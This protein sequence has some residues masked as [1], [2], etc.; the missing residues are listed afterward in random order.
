MAEQY[1][2]EVFNKTAAP[3]EVKALVHDIF[4]KLVHK[5]LEYVKDK[6]MNQAQNRKKH[7]KIQ[8]K[9]DNEAQ[10]NKFV[11]ISHAREENANE[12]KQ[13]EE[14]TKEFVKK[15]RR[16]QK[17]RERRLKAREEEEKQKLL[18]ET[19]EQD[20]Q[21]KEE[22]S[23]QEEEKLR[24]VK[25]L[26]N[27]S[28]KRKEEIK[29]LIELGN[30]EYKKVISSKPLHEIIEEK[31]YSN[32]LMPELERHKIELAK[33]REL[34]QPINRSAILEHAKRHDQLIEE[35]DLQ[36]RNISQDSTYDASKLR[37]KYALAYIEEQRKK[38]H[39][40]END[41]LEKKN[42]LEKKKQYAELVLEMYQPTVDPA[43]QL[44]LKLIKEK[45]QVSSS[46]ITKK[47]SAKSLSAKE[48]QSEGEI[49]KRKW[50][51]N[52]MIPEPP[53]KRE[54]VKIDWLADQR[55]N[56]ENLSDDNELAKVDWTNELSQGKIKSKVKKLE[57]QVRK[58]EMRLEV[59]NPSNMKGIDTT[60]HVSDMLIS[61]IK[62]KLAILEKS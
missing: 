20:I 55:K 33:K 57:D 5:T 56:R 30:Q 21:R 19:K 10:I 35:H 44:E 51:K 53:K 42:L 7:K 2:K 48:G 58:Q 37:S 50:N 62:G 18:Q 47:R 17:E 14:E 23:R 32:V 52:S 60:A 11:P 4:N 29:E 12:F 46:N 38:K 54:P 6:Y 27:K 22:I 36:K 9:D 61:S 43:K 31:Y 45:L 59:V 13:K 39:D 1:L 24:R 3:K 49:K 41:I 40:L 26:K 16:E 28:K 15:L 8:E 34:L 25:D